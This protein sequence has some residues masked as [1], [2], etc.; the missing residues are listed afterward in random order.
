MK[1]LKNVGLRNVL[2]SMVLAAGALAVAPA[3]AKANVDATVVTAVDRVASAAGSTATIK[4]SAPAVQMGKR[5][6]PAVV[7][8]EQAELPFYF[9]SWVLALLTL[10]IIVAFKRPWGSATTKTSERSAHGAAALATPFLR[11]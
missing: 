3:Q 5:T 10:F 2:L 8:G 7:V 9:K 6:T 1:L 4:D 11:S